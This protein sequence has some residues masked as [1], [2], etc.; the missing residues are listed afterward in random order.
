MKWYKSWTLWFNVLCGSLE[1]LQYMIGAN[2]I[3]APMSIAIITWGNIILRVLKTTDPITFAKKFE[4]DFK[5]GK[6]K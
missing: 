4:A 3:S 2:I 5:T 6:V 1:T